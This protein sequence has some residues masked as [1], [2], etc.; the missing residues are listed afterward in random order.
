MSSLS[1][2]EFCALGAGLFLPRPRARAWGVRNVIWIWNEGGMGQRHTWDP[3]PPVRTID[4]PVD[5]IRLSEHMPVCA[6]QMAHL[7]ILRSMSHGL[8]DP[9]V[10]AR[11]MHTA[12]V[13]PGNAPVASLGCLLAY[14]LS[15]RDFPLAPFVSLGRHDIPHTSPFGEE[16]LPL[17]ASATPE[18]IPHL[19]GPV[20]ST[21]DAARAA[22]L[23]EQD[24]EWSARRLLPQ[25]TKV[26]RSF[27]TSETLMRSPAIKVFDLAEEPEA[28][29]REYGDGFGQGCLAARRLVEAGCPFVE[30]GFRGWRRKPNELPP[31]GT[32]APVLDRGLGT[33]VKDLAACGLL[34]QTLVVCATEFGKSALGAPQPTGFSVVLAGGPLRGG[35][36]VGDTGADGTAC[37]GPVS[38]PALFATIYKAAGVDP[39]KLYRIERHTRRYLSEGKPLEDVF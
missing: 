15:N 6:S 30:V 19:R 26:K 33:L 2:R 28:L 7:T 37:N 17:K 27:L 39:G 5:G 16:Y 35:T 34:R 29:R 38:V 36:V 18:P 31:D 25:V 3:K 24:E 21:R 10:A 12:V 9:G 14:E 22:L 32:L 8:G 20:E 4:T 11:F 1:R 13:A 23:V